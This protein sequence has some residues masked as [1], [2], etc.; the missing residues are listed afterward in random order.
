MTRWGIERSLR[1]LGRDLHGGDRA[2]DRKDWNRRVVL[3]VA[4]AARRRRNADEGTDL[5]A[6]LAGF[7]IGIE[8]GV[9]QQGLLVVARP[10][11][12]QLP[13]P[14][15]IDLSRVGRR[16]PVWNAAGADHRDALRH[17]VS[18]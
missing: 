13:V 15:F 3:Y 14:G 5:E 9:R 6:A 18:G 7:P 16:R 1:P 4:A 8:V 11:L 10:A 2:A 12:Q 17:A